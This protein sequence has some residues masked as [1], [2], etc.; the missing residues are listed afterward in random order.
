MSISNYFRSVG[1]SFK[2]RLSIVIFLYCTLVAIR[3]LINLTLQCVYLF[4]ERSSLKKSDLEGR[5]EAA[6]SLNYILDWMLLFGQT[7][8]TDEAV[9]AFYYS[10]VFAWTVVFCLL[11]PLKVFNYSQGNRLVCFLLNPENEYIEIKKKI[12]ACLWSIIRSNITFTEIVTGHCDSEKEDRKNS[13]LNLASKTLLDALVKPTELGKRDSRDYSK[14]VS[15]NH[16]ESDKERVRLRSAQARLKPNHEDWTAKADLLNSL[17]RQLNF[18]LKLRTSDQKSV[19]PL[20]RNKIWHD[21]MCRSGTTFF[22]F[23]SICYW[24]IGEL[25]CVSRYHSIYW[26]MKESKIDPKYRYYTFIDRLSCVDYHIFTFVAVDSFLASTT[27]WYTTVKDQIK[28]LSSLKPRLFQVVEKINRLKLWLQ[29][30]VNSETQQFTNLELMEETRK[31]LE[32]ECDIEA[33]KLYVSYQIFRDE[34]KSALRVAQ[35]AANQLVTLIILSLLPILAFY[36]EIPQQHK[37]DF[38]FV[39]MMILML[40][41]CSFLL[42]ATLH[43]ACGHLARLTWPFVAFIE[44][45]NSEC[46]AMLEPPFGVEWDKRKDGT[47]YTLSRTRVV[48][49][50]TELLL[51]RLLQSYDVLA[52]GSVCK[53]YGVLRL[54]FSGVLRI[55]YWL[56]CAWLISLT[57][58][59]EVSKGSLSNHHIN[60]T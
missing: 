15:S 10:I 36:K 4:T 54:N 27:I 25:L 23:C 32:F 47:K 5:N 2:S 45:T 34:V 28:T 11:V 46:L 6:N 55:N 53:L 8:R 57:F 17:S 51:R 19:W 39:L 3:S 41:N 38:Y 31:D 52:E 14:V 35:T 16:E 20:N 18:L 29:R 59:N 50:H 21:E 7:F 37:K 33:L 9:G 12:D 24:L 60:T 56:V 44:K 42:C 49:P 1:S 58:H 43:S 40:L 48:T 22:T 13:T 26:A 30:A